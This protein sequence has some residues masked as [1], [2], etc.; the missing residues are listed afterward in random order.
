MNIDEYRVIPGYDAYVVTCEGIVLSTERNLELSRYLLNG[1]LIVNTF[2]GSLTETLPVHRA[3]ALAWVDNPDPEQFV[4]VNHKD[5]DPL[6]NHYSNLEWTDASGN[7][8]HAIN[9]GLRSDNIPCK[10]RDFYT[11]NVMEF[12]S[13]AQAAEF[14]GFPKDTPYV[15]LRPKMFGKL[16]NGR[17]EFRQS[18]DEA[19]W[20]YESRTSLV[21]PSRYM[22]KVTL[23]TGELKEVYS[24]TSFLKD[25]QLYGSRS[26]SI[27]TLVEYAAE[28]YP[29]HQFV[30]LDS[31]WEQQPRIRRSTRNNARISLWALS[32][33]SK[34]Y[35]ES[36]TLC[37]RHFRV[38]RSSILNR[39]NTD[40]ELSGW[41]FT[42]QICPPNS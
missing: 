32:N 14:M 36:L 20:F 25:F 17:F 11:G 30:V 6:N 5:G 19:P 4:M 40:K 35:F 37:A 15:S 8:Y 27:P 29:D 34:V 31:Y 12:S 7:N 18:G 13:M 9:S 16:L 10:V 41:T 26:K 21:K 22:V 23:P 39:L 38:D 42:T 3:V 24:T 28:M 33:N 1:Y 2:R